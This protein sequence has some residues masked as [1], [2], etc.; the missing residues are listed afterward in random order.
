MIEKGTD[1]YLLDTSAVLAFIEDEPG[2]DRVEGLLRAETV[3]LPFVAGL[4]TY[5]VTL[6]ERGED[7]ANRRIFLLHQLPVRWLDRV[8][9][10]ILVTAGRVKAQHHLTL[11]DCLVAAFAIDAGA[12]LVHKDPEYD[13]LSDVRQEHL[14]YK[15]A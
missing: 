6:R 2:A 7:E 10:T 8:S 3:L 12:V 4:E 9:D 14:P 11:A 1:T 5:Y 13:A 15:D